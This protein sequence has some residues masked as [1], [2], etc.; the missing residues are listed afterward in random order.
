MQ[1]SALGL[2]SDL[3]SRELVAEC[4]VALFRHKKA[5]EAA[6]KLEFYEI[7]RVWHSLETDNQLK[8]VNE[9]IVHLVHYTEQE[10]EDQDRQGGHILP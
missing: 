9:D 2:V 6:R 1:D 8:T 4:L 3:F 5:R 10:L 7:F